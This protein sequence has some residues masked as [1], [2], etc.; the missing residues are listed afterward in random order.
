MGYSLMG[1]TKGLLLQGLT[2]NDKQINLCENIYILTP[3]T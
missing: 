1:T 2:L 3:T